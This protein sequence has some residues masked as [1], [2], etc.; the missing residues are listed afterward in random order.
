MLESEHTLVRPDGHLRFQIIPHRCVR[1]QGHKGQ[2]T[3]YRKSL[4]SMHRV[5]DWWWGEG[6]IKYTYA[7][8]H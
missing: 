7:Q 6:I 1:V 8:N 3:L 4:V 2:V 5:E